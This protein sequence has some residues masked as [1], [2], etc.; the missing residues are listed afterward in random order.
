MQLTK[1]IQKNHKSIIKA[2]VDFARTMQ[3]WAQGMS[4]KDLQDHAEELLVA[5]VNDMNSPQSK[6][7]QSEK[8]QGNGMDGNLVIAG[9]Q[10]ASTRL[11]SGLSLT[12]LVSE[13]RALR[14]SVLR[15]W[16]EEQG[17]ESDEVTRFNEAIDEALATSMTQYSEAVDTTREQFLAILSH[18]LRN[19]LGA[20]IM[21]A[22]LLNDPETEDT[23]D[24][25]TVI[26]NSAERMSR[27]VSDLLDL[28][29]TRLGTGIPIAT[30][31]MD[32]ASVCQ[33]VFAEFHASH[34]PDHRI[35]FESFGDLR[36]EWDADR[37]AQVLSN[38]I[39]NALQYGSA[40]KPVSLVAR[41][42]GQE[43]ELQV[44]NEGSP[45]PESSLKTI[46]APMVRHKSGASGVDKNV[47][48]LGLGLYIANEVVL[49]HSGTISVTSTESS[50]T[51]FTV[52]LPR[53][54]TAKTPQQPTLGMPDSSC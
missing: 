6:S 9:Q 5:V 2:W 22:Q 3:P 40:A 54:S 11:Q 48:G 8:S 7:E 31:P 14:A 29:R 17:A 19:P 49:S 46:F 30:K 27:M 51:T 37:L 35:H 23:A 28:T 41:D 34:A 39:A 16:E 33:Q 1:F 52:T 38:L 36:G 12:Q 45:I 13:F 43:V 10:H 15:Q 18:D 42:R 20:I 32:L 21:G 53:L 47:S 44:H 26:L 25:A 24:I 50:G 4:E